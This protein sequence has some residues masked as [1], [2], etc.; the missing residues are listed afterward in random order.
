MSV[1]SAYKQAENL[2]PDDL[3]P[4]LKHHFTYS[5]RDRI[6]GRNYQVQF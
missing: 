5:V 3:K 6:A 1:I 4:M 2:K